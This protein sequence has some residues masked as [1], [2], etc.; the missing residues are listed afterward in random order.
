MNTKRKGFIVIEIVIISVITIVLGGVL[1]F[2]NND[3]ASSAQASRI[4]NNFRNMKTAA[5]AW[6]QDN[7]GHIRQGSHNRQEILK[8]LKSR[9]PIKLAE[10]NTEEGSYMLR[11]TD[12]GKS[13]YIGY[14]LTDNKG[15][16]RKLTAKAEAANL[17]GSDM[18]STYNN[19]SQVWMQ[20]LS[21]EG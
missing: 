15:I 21:T 8:Y 11:L 12:D 10:D 17:L 7:H 4:I 6:Q 1:F 5:A 20:V 9:T 19:D 14:E 18:K 13:L 16:K 3:A 2:M